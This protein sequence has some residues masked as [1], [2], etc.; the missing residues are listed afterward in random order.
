MTSRGSAG[1]EQATVGD[2]GTRMSTNASHDG[3]RGAALAARPR[4]HVVAARRRHPAAGRRSSGCSRSRS[5][6]VMPVITAG[7]HRRRGLAGRRLAAARRPAARARGRAADARRDRRSASGWSLLIVGGITSETAGLSGH[8]IDAQNT[9]EGWLQ[10][11]GIDPST[12]ENAKDTASAS[13]QRGL[14]R[15]STASSRDS[16]SSPR[17]SSSSSLTALSLFFLLKDGPTIRRWAE[18]HLGV[19]RRWRTRSPSASLASLRGYFLG[20]TIVAA[21]QRGR[22][23]RRAR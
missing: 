6:I 20:V 8:L 3:P 17:W 10:D 9:I 4:P 18:R 14:Q 13:A 7:G 12:A 16:R 23:R 15:C 1:A 5:T 2:A 22:G 21:V 11:L 19:P